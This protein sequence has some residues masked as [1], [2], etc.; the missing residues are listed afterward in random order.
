MITLAR[1][2]DEAVAVVRRLH[3][4]ASRVGLILGSG[5]SDIFGGGTP[6]AVTIPFSQLPHLAPTT[7]AGH[8]GALALGQLGGQEVAIMRGRLH[9]YEGY[10]PSQVAFPVRLLQAL[11]C[12]TLMITNAAGGLNPDFSA[13]DLMVIS[14]HIFLPGMVGASPLVGSSKD[15]LGP[16][17]V[18]MAPAYSPE[19]RQLA[20]SVAGDQSLALQE[21]VYAM[22]AGPHYETPAEARLLRLAGA[23]AVGMSTCP[24]VVAARQVG[25]GVLGISTIANLAIG[26]A[27]HYLTHQQ[28]LLAAAQAE[29]HLA[30]L[31]IGI[32]EQIGSESG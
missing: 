25:M 21:G 13:G 24:E 16:R 26:E 30:R 31:I 18:S 14:D 8:P 17:F 15:Q 2:V 29:P 4:K 11:G 32:L 28:V 19:L 23:D 20:R 22:V 12:E 7:V 9:L 6:A 10:S 5:L 1:Q 3:P 27:H